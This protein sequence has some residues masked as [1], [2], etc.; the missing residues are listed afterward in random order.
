MRNALTM[1]V[2]LG[3]V[4]FASTASAAT[5]VTWH[6]P[7]PGCDSLGK[8]HFTCNQ[9]HHFTQLALVDA[10]GV[11]LGPPGQQQCPECHFTNPVDPDSVLCHNGGIHRYYAPFWAGYN[12]YRQ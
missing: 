12:Y 9:G 1:A 5:W 3:L 10:D 2:V 4:L 7:Y 8:V 6:C 11:V